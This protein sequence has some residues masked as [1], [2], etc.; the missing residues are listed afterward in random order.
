METRLG[1]L[2][3]EGGGNEDGGIGG[4]GLGNEDGEVERVLR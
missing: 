3:E 2:V 1:E 4:G